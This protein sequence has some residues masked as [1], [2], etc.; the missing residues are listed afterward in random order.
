MAFSL[1]LPSISSLARGLLYP[2]RIYQGGSKVNFLPCDIIELHEVQSWETPTMPI[3]SGSN[4]SDTIYTMPKSI[5]CRVY[6]NTLEYDRFCQQLLR[7]QYASG[8]DI[9]GV[10]Y[11]SYKGFRLLDKSEPQTADTSGAYLI[12]LTFQ[13]VR[14]VK[15]FSA[16]IAQVQAKKPAYSG[17][18]NKG[19]QAPKQAPKSTL[20]GL[21]D[22]GASFIF[23]G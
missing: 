16:G 10:D 18:V 2:M 8:F 17:K 20:K 3:D 9:Q 21:K 15:G 13:E 14:I 6:V 7:W 4:I 23:G 11:Q 22:H 5:T 12:N 1:A 19:A